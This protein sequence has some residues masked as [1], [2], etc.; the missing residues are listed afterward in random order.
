MIR[1]LG[2]VLAVWGGM[3]LLLVAVTV[4][5]QWIEERSETRRIHREIDRDWK[6]LSDATSGIDIPLPPRK[7][8]A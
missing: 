6:A 2:W 8:T 5:T 1:Q 7:E 3:C 4:L